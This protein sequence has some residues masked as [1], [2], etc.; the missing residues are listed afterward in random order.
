MQNFNA[1]DELELCFVTSTT[2][3]AGK[4]GQFLVE[5]AAGKLS[6]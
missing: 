4:P 3:D 1:V 2:V 6:C 5:S